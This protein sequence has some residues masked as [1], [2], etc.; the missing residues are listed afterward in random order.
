MSYTPPKNENFFVA[1]TCNSIDDV[2]GAKWKRSHLQIR[3]DNFLVVPEANNPRQPQDFAP[4][5]QPQ[6]IV[7][8]ARPQLR[9]PSLPPTLIIV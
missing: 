8:D 6:I 1:G 9:V 3:W 2:T 4:D 5:I 7:Q